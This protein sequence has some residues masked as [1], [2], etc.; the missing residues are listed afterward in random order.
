MVITNT[1]PKQKKTR[2][3][4]K[5]PTNIDS[6][7]GTILL[8]GMTFN[9]LGD[10]QKARKDWLANFDKDAIDHARLELKA[11]N[12]EIKRRAK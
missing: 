4:T 9:E 12:N 5:L 8:E 1:T 2:E 11:I 6:S 3:K 7:G 10:A